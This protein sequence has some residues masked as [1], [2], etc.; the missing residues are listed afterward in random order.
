MGDMYPSAQRDDQGGQHEAAQ[1]CPQGYLRSTTICLSRF[2]SAGVVAAPKR[3]N[4]FLRGDTICL[5]RIAS[6]GVVAK[7][8]RADGFRQASWDTSKWRQNW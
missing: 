6:H 4:G 1:L 5:S 3:A 2:A 8:S 7:P